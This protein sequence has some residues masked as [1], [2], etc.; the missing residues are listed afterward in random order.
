MRKFVIIRIGLV[1]FSVCAILPLL[2][3]VSLC[4]VEHV[5]MYSTP[6]TEEYL[7]NRYCLSLIPNIKIDSSSKK[8]SLRFTSRRDVEVQKARVYFN[9]RG[10]PGNVRIGIQKDDGGGEPSGTYLGYQDVD[11]ISKEDWYVATLSPAVALG[12]NSVYHVVISPLNGYDANNH[13]LIW[14][15]DPHNRMYPYNQEP[16]DNLNSLYYDGGSWSAQNKDPEFM[17]DLTNGE[18]IGITYNFF[19]DTHLYGEVRAGEEFLV[20]EKSCVVKGVSAYMKRGPTPPEDDLFVSIYDVTDSS[21]VV[22]DEKFC[23]P[24]DVGGSY[25]WVDHWFKESLV[26]EAGKTYRVFWESPSVC[27]PQYSYMMKGLT[28]E[29][30]DPYAK[31]TY[32]GL[33]SCYVYGTTDPPTST[34]LGSDLVYSLWL[35]AVRRVPE[36]YQTI[37]G[38]IDAADDGDI[39][40]VAAAKYY[41][42]VAVDKTITLLGEEGTIID[43]GGTGTVISVTRD[44][45]KISGFTIQKGKRGIFLSPPDSIGTLV[46]NDIRNNTLTSHTQAA[47]ELWYSNGTT[48]SDNKISTNDHGIWLKFSSCSSTIRNNELKDNS[49][50]LAISSN[51][52]ANTIVGNTVI[53]NSFEGIVLGWNNNN[54]IYHNNFVDNKDQVYSYNSS[55]TWDNGAEGNYWSDYTGEDQDGDGIGDTLLPHKGL[56][57]HPLIEPWSTV[58]RFDVAWFNE[59]YHITTVCNSTVASFKFSWELKQTSFNVTGPS[60]TGGFCNVTIPKKLLWADSPEDWSVEV[61]DTSTSS[62]IFENVT[63]SSLYLSYTCGALKVKITGTSVVQDTTPPVASAG[64]SQT[65]TEDEPLTFDASASSD[66]IGIVDYEW[67]F[68]DDTTG[69][70]MIITHTYQEPGIYSVTLRVKDEAGNN[71]TDSVAITVLAK[72]TDDGVHDATD[73]DGDGM[74]DTWET[75]NHLGPLNATDATLDPDNDGLTNLIE[76]E[77]NTNPHAY[78]SDGDF[79]TDSIDPMPGNAL[80]PNGPIIIVGVVCV[81]I[82]MLKGRKRRPG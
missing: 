13:I 34:Y 15:N 53:S 62:T 8:A 10:L 4:T 54:T 52:N 67:A 18:H 73:T 40:E 57:Y 80:I 75:D 71:A 30:L 37:Q 69:T 31:V 49:Q 5:D 24:S 59:T 41:E 1:L 26:L 29:S 48:I 65:V 36:E 63:H 33:D 56:D 50:G 58:R 79:W 47:I 12:E 55:N 20:K 44:N 7:G 72:D 76:Y 35:A 70:G 17:L 11:V 82:F 16:D 68:G 45:V 32:D 9:V 2:H 64:P 77:R 60:G 6:S 23:S 14:M 74:P 22:R 66:N 38:A 39:I 21:W 19:P 28:S 3:E 43:G 27:C 81:S 42:H 78:D 61:D 46:G 25:S 51:C